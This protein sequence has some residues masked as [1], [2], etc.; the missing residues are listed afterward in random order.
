M[1][2]DFQRNPEEC[3][4]RVVAIDLNEMPEFLDLTI[5][6]FGDKHELQILM[7]DDPKIKIAFEK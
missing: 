6:V 4:Y 1:H 7:S 5:Q 3:V 2:N